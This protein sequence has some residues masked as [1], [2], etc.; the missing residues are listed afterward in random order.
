MSLGSVQQ[1]CRVVVVL[2]QSIIEAPICFVEAAVVAVR[3][4]LIGKGKGG[5][6]LCWR[7]LS[8]AA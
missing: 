8:G 7:P 3:A 5:H 6:G 4:R 1:V 2:L